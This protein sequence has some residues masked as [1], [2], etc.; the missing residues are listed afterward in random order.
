VPL[1]LSRLWRNA[2]L[3]RRRNSCVVRPESRAP[4]RLGPQLA[5]SRTWGETTVVHSSSTPEV[6]D[7]GS[8][9]LALH[10]VL[11]DTPSVVEDIV[12]DGIEILACG[13]WTWANSDHEVR[14]GNRH[15]DANA[16]GLSVPVSMVRR[17][18]GYAA[19]RDAIKKCLELRC[20]P[21]DVVCDGCR[22]L[23]AAE[24]DLNGGLHVA[25][26]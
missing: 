16:M 12:D 25:S 6:S 13:I 26:I 21:I 5:R 8:P 14:P 11:K 17:L 15:L 1:G 10:M 2:T 7:G 4:T 20:T 19:M 22:C 3:A 18:D 24:R 9:S 23:D